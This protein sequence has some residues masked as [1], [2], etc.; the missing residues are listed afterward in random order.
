VGPVTGLRRGEEQEGGVRSGPGAARTTLVADFCFR[1]TLE[2]WAM[3]E[4]WLEGRGLRTNGSAARVRTC[5]A[6]TFKTRAQEG[7]NSWHARAPR[8]GATL[9]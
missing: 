3:A 1:K 6:T 8:P 5:W 2:R 7:R 4:G 9:E